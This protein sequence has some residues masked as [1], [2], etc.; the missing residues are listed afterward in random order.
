VTSLSALATAG[1]GIAVVQYY[2]THGPVIKP[3]W[4]S[5]IACIV[6]GIGTPGVLHGTMLFTPFLFR[7]GSVL[8]IINQTRMELAMLFGMAVVWISGALAL[9]CDLRGRENCL[10]CA[11]VTSLSACRSADLLLNRQQGWILPLPQAERLRQRLQP[12]TPPSASPSSRCASS[13]PL[14]DTR[15]STWIKR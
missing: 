14:P 6:F 3:S 9:A 15:Y 2:N 8:G 1:V 13:L 10:W 11:E 7:H 4:G 12:P 5:L